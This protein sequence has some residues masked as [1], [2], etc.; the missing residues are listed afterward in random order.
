[1]VCSLVLGILWQA[2]LAPWT[3]ELAI[4]F[5]FVFAVS[6]LEDRKVIF[7]EPG[8]L[9]WLW[10]IAISMVKVEELGREAQFGTGHHKRGEASSEK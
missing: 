10:L 2:L 7:V 4:E 6:T 3:L 1:M 8:I 5:E 9:L